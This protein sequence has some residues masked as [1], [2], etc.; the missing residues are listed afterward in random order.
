MGRRMTTHSGEEATIWEGQSQ[1]IT[2]MA[3]GGRVVLHYRLTTH[4]VYF[5][6][7]GV[8]RTRSEQ[9]PLLAVQDVDISQNLVQK[10]RGVGNVLVHIVRHNGVRETA[11]ID[12]VPEP[13]R[14]RDLV[15]Q[16]V[17]QVRVAAHQPQ[18]AQ[19]KHNNTELL[20]RL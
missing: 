5:E 4:Y 12:S 2:A 13:A 3:T 14:V 17:H 16:A 9:V 7:G 10:S 8:T 1:N 20:A 6:R 19:H 18:I 11:T 15:N